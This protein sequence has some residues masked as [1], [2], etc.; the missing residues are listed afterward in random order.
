VFEAQFRGVLFDGD[1]G[2]RFEL[3]RECTSAHARVFGERVERKLP[4]RMLDEQI[5][6]DMN[7]TREM[8]ALCEV[9]AQLL[10]RPR[11][12]HGDHHLARDLRGD[13][14]AVPA[15]EQRQR[16]VDTRSY[17]RARCETPIERVQAISN[18]V[19]ARKCAL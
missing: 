3:T 16:K 5:L 10:V 13:A 2:C 18:N 9:W 19:C 11:P 6:N 4:V 1:S 12:T 14:R 8:I 7:L 17:A 15:L